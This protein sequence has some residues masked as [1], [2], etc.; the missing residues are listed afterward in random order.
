MRDSVLIDTEAWI[1]YLQ[2]HAPE[3]IPGRVDELLSRSDVCVP[4]IVIAELIQN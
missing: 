3:D 4:K 1:A 2:A